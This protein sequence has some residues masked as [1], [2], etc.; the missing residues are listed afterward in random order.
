MSSIYEAISTN[1]NI[2][3]QKLISQQNFNIDENILFGDTYFLPLHLVVIYNNVDA[4]LL[5]LQHG[6]NVNVLNEYGRTALH[7][8]CF[9]KDYT[10]IKILL[11][12]GADI[13]IVTKCGMTIF[14]WLKLHGRSESIQY[15]HFYLKAKE[16]W[17][18]WEIE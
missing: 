4:L 10:M 9:Y 6:A 1:N 16:L 7:R 13:D 14:S 17:F 3:L 18:L 8:A 11:D 5:L 12:Y 15:I 2:L